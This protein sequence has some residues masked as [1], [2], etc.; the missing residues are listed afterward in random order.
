MAASYHVLLVE[1][2]ADLAEAVGDYL[3]AAGHTVD[4]AA[5]GNQAVSLTEQSRYDIIVLDVMLPGMNG[6][7]VC[8]HLRSTQKLTTPVI[9]LTAKDQ[10]TDKLEG[11][12]SG[13][14]D[15][16]VKPFDMPELEARLHALVRRERGLSSTYEVEDL[17]LDL[18]TLRVH[19]GEQELVLSG[20]GFEILK[21]LMREHPKVVTR[22]ELERE[23]WGEEPPD[24]DALRSHMYNLRQ[25]VDRPF[26]NPLIETLPGRGYRLRSEAQS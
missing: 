15:Y 5:D 6:F 24:S 25:L 26:A 18:E 2:H 7:E 9:M 19:R 11:F 20:I 1:D 13:A 4:F 3:E 23:L 8:A 10:L 16:L 12:E 21:V 14:D 22:A 17:K